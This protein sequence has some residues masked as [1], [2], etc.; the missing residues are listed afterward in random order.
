MR[1]MVVFFDSQCGQQ[2]G[3]Q[4]VVFQQ[5]V[6][7]GGPLQL[8]QTARQTGRRGGFVARKKARQAQRF[9]LNHRVVFH[10]KAVQVQGTRLEV[11]VGAQVFRDVLGQIAN[12][13]LVAHGVVDQRQTLVQP[14]ALLVQGLVGPQVFQNDPNV[15]CHAALAGGFQAE[16]R[17]QV[18]R[19]D[20]SGHGHQ[21]ARLS[22]HLAPQQAH[23]HGQVP[24]GE[25]QRR[26]T[27]RQDPGAPFDFWGVLGFHQGVKQE[28]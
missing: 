24:E 19:H 1:G 8:F 4:V 13:V 15:V 23:D 25:G 16:L 7:V 3:R 28:V 18:A 2:F 21:L 9:A 26:Q 5:A 27:G 22:T 20:V 12:A 17:R 14:Q 11:E 10:P 6:A